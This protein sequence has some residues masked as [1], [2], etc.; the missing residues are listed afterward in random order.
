MKTKIGL[1]L[2]FALLYSSAS[3]ADGG[4]FIFRVN[5]ESYSFPADCVES[6]EFHDKEEGYPERIDMRL[7]D[8]CG[9][10]VSDLTTQNIGK[11]MTIY[12]EHNQLMSATIA[13]RLRSNIMLPTTK[14]PRVVL[15]QVLV[16]YGVNA[17]SVG[18]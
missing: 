4:D 6:L 13:S 14:T 8:E 5:D 3:S 9:R 7:T 11:Q 1:F 10:R 17:R 12:Y 16:D 2:S 15:M 18:R